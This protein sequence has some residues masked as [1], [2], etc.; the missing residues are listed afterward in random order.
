MPIGLGSLFVQPLVL[1]SLKVVI[2]K[3]WRKQPKLA[4]LADPIL[5]LLLTNTAVGETQLRSDM[6]LIS[7]LLGQLPKSMPRKPRSQFVEMTADKRLL[8]RSTIID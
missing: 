7:M 3:T 4:L 2:I 5:L 1:R 8:L 6:A